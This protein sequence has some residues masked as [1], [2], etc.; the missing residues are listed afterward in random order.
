MSKLLKYPNG[1]NV[2]VINMPVRSVM[3]GFW[4]GTGSKNETA[5]INGISHFTE[6]VMFKGTET[7]T[8]FDIAG[9]FEGY[10]AMINAF[11]SKEATCYYFKCVD[12]YLDPCFELLSE[13]FF[14]STYDDGELDKERNVIVEELNMVEDAPDEICS[15]LLASAAYGNSGL[16]QTIL[17][18]KENILKFKGDDV[19]AYVKNR[20]T[21][22]NTAIV[23]VGNVSEEQADVLVRKYALNSFRA[24]KAVASVVDYTFN[25]GVENTRFK[26]FEQ[27]NIALAYPSVS[28]RDGKGV[29]VQSVFSCLFGGGMSSRLFQSVRERLGLAYSI[30]TS[31]AA[32]DGTG[33]FGIYLNNSPS[34]TVKAISAIKS[35]IDLLLDKGI[36]EEEFNR[37]KI[38][39]ISSMVFSNES[40][41]SIMIGNGKNLL[42]GDGLLNVDEKIALIEG[43]TL[44]DVN[45]FARRTL[46]CNKLS[47][48]YVG[49]EF[50]GSILELLK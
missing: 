3:V 44:S 45:E 49:K 22:D 43:V 17:G 15:D 2:G 5:D 26:D 37:A 8:A 11:T 12:K 50:G 29:A 14:K 28:I 18:P 38:Q 27:T 41:Q 13:I 36:I 32:Y 48:A 16:G 47:A 42:R 25:S 19:R 39:I 46:D 33:L 35:E 4:V 10:G 40:M 1:L 30:Y 34:N 31:C 23:L 9:A 20:Y 6:H 7:M 24:E 21:P